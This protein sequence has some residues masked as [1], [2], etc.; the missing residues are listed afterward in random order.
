VNGVST[1]TEVM[2]TMSPLG[3]GFP[4]QLT[5]THAPSVPLLP[6][7]AGAMDI[8]TGPFVGD[9]G[10]SVPVAGSVGGLELTSEDGEPDAEPESTGCTQ[11]AIGKTRKVI[12][13]S[14][15]LCEVYFPSRRAATIR[16]TCS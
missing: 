10:A 5:R 13:A 14:D 11:A 9:T 7:G 3:I 16:M 12:Q 1:I 8:A 6:V 2:A 4:S 15:S